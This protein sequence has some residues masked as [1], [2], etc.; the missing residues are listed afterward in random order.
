MGSTRLPG[1]VLLDLNGHS[2]LARVVRRT[3]RAKLLDEVTVAC[4]TEPADEAIVSECRKLGVRVHRGSGSDVLSRYHG[5]ASEFG[6]DAVVRIT[7]DCPL[8][9]PEIVDRVVAEF[10]RSGA[11]Y[12]SNTIDRSYPRG[13]DTEVFKK[14]ALDRAC[15]E[16]KE[17]YEHV[18]VTPFLYHHPELFKVVQV[19]Q[20]E[21]LNELRWTVDTPEDFEFVSQIYRHFN[22]NDDF[23][24]L[25]VLAYLEKNPKVSEIN[26]HIR[27]KQLKEL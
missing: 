23:S 24:W 14:S 26:S 21:D 18:H 17:D 3:Q 8:I 1:K 11:D 2:M 20:A 13:L 12:A 7:S 16:A 6:A 19:K 9:E 22:G 5:A 4:S 10:Q 27:Q 15:K 25:D